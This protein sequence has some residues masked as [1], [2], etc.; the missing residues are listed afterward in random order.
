MNENNYGG[1][2]D[3]DYSA[4][5]S[6][7]GGP[8]G[9]TAPVLDDIDYVPPSAKKGGPTGVTA[10]VLDDMD[11]YV[12]PVK[13]KKGAPTGVSAPVLDDEAA[14]YEAEKEEKLI[15]TD[16]EIIQR[17]TADQLETYNR[18]PEANKQ[19]VLELMRNQLGAEAPK[20]EV[21]APVLDDDNY[22]PPE[23]K[24]EAEP[25]PEP[26]QPVTA[27]ILDDAPETP[28]YKPK[29]VDE[30]LERA[31]K[32]AAKKA[33]SSQLVSEQ[34]DSKESLRM[35]LELKEERR[36]EDAKRGFKV[37]IVIA[38]LGVAAAVVFYL[39]YS[40][41]LG[42]TYD[43]S[44]LSKAAGIIKN[45][46]MYIAIAMGVSSLTLITGVG[47]F[48][49]LAT[50]IHLLSAIIQVFPG[51]IMISQHNGS[52]GLAIALY[53]VSIICTIS[54]FVGLSAIES[55]GRFYNKNLR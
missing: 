23:P 10:P 34:K 28:A 22:I 30:D 14:V 2:D 25:Q 19:K 43:E 20:E 15:M 40:G 17:F 13:E 21:K 18:L 31:K 46:S 26:E 39:L 36:R 16:E 45:S 48:K 35:M 52:T 9:V 50:I 27:P 6:N 1:L 42:L 8:T 33:V 3:I 41:S 32:E 47:F 5:P 7:N 38:L 55:V 12:P 49:S 54:V 4:Q 29:F 11:A 53:A 51:F 44:G 37:V 24:K